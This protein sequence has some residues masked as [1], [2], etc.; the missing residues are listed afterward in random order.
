MAVKC[1]PIPLKIPALRALASPRRPP[2]LRRHAL[3]CA[4]PPS[5]HPHAVLVRQ[6]APAPVKVAVI[7]DSASA[8]STDITKFFSDAFKEFTGDPNAIVHAENYQT[9]I[10]NP[11]PYFSQ[12]ISQIFLF[13]N[14]I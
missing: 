7:Q 2:T 11:P 3:F 5:Q 12:N 9:C 14:H 1:H 4:L 8:Y 6:A 13:L 10:L